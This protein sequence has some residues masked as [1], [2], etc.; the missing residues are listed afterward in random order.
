MK[1]NIISLLAALIFLNI[2]ILPNNN[3]VA[4]AISTNLPEN[5]EVSDYLENTT[6]ETLKDSYIKAIEQLEKEKQETTDTQIISS[7]EQEIQ[8]NKT[9]LQKINTGDI[10]NSTL[11][12]AKKLLNGSISKNSSSTYSLTKS[13]YDTV[14][15][16]ILLIIGFGEQNYY[17]AAANLLKYSLTATPNSTY[18]VW[19]NHSIVAYRI[20]LSS[21]YK[22][23]VNN[24]SSAYASSNS[25][26]FYKF[27][28]NFA[29]NGGTTLVEKDLY[30]AIHGCN[31]GVDVSIENGYGN[32][33]FRDYYDFPDV[34]YY[35]DSAGTI[36][37]NI[38]KTA[39]D[40]GVCKPYYLKCHAVEPFYNSIPN[41][42]P[43]YAVKYGSTG[44]TVTKVQQRLNSLGFSISAD[45]SFG[46]ATDTAVKNFQRTRGI[47]VDGSVGPTTWD[48]LF[49]KTFKPS[50]PGTAVHY[51]S[52]GTI[53]LMVQARLNQLGY[54]L[55][56]P[57]GSFGPA[58][59]NAVLNFQKSKGLSQDGYCGPATWSKLF[60]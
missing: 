21:Y 3:I 13:S 43:G 27:E 1:K 53:V 40:L 9:I 32:L 30:Y 34:S 36:L 46:P 24:L 44:S 18:D 51:G 58:T 10:S 38:G 2:L 33:V 26:N 12:D 29:F 56:A 8:C 19:N 35:P 47:S 37:N 6:A 23:L 14:Y 25:V 15:S 50:Y 55:G 11:N 5:T 57:D 28:K 4:N 39:M 45:G 7:I 49:N 16:T 41:S 22:S 59:K 20:K 17:T 52:T 42:Y 54:N 31:P 60:G 48:Y